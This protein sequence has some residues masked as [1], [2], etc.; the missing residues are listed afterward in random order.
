LERLKTTSAL[1]QVSGC[2][3]CGAEPAYWKND[4]DHF[5]TRKEELIRERAG[6]VS[7][8]ND[9]ETQ[10]KNMDRQRQQFESDQKQRS[11]LQLFQERQQQ[12]LAVCPAY[13]DEA[14]ARLATLDHLRHSLMQLESL[15]PELTAQ[16]EREELQLAGKRKLQQELLS[17]LRRL[18][19]DREKWRTE[20]PGREER[21]RLN[22][23][24]LRLTDEINRSEN[25]LRQLA[26]LEG[27]RT[28]SI[29]QQQDF[30][31]QKQEYSLIANEAN[32]IWLERCESALD[33]F[34]HDRLPRLIHKSF[35]D[36][37]VKV[38]NGNLAG[39]QN[40]FEVQV[41]DDVS[42]D[43]RFADGETRESKALS[44]GESDLLGISFLGAVNLTSAQKLGI[45]VIDEPTA[46]LDAEN[47][48]SLF[49]VLE[50]WK[51]DMIRQNR[52]LI[53]VTHVEEM[54][55]IADTVFRLPPKEGWSA[56]GSNVL[57]GSLTNKNTNHSLIL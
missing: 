29:R 6:V 38:V 52:Q 55:G 12:E 10:L 24:A 13:D 5:R 43:I 48:V 40:P 28:E 34:H 33:W 31:H 30:E 21:E 36:T 42:F 47:L 44:V 57:S 4:V 35:L 39:F 51:K 46:S 3:F 11:R 2:P 17:T 19:T 20:L 32:E 14:Q 45:M 15:L 56:P 8:K 16:T 1:D 23:D 7:R 53:I 18:E 49:Q 9:L 37:L 22:D 50:Q 27:S 26:E 25:V 54:A 41:N